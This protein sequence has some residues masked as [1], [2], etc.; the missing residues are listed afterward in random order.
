MMSVK[1]DAERGGF[2]PYDSAGNPLWFYGIFQSEALFYL[3]VCYD[4]FFGSP[5]IFKYRVKEARDA[6]LGAHFSQTF[7]G[8]SL[9]NTN[10]DTGAGFNLSPE[11][12]NATSY[13]FTPNLEYANYPLGTRGQRDAEDFL[14]SQGGCVRATLT[15]QKRGIDLIAMGVEY[16]VKSRG[17]GQR[18]RVLSIQ[19]HERNDNRRIS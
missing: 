12:L 2:F 3:H 16:E 10:D 11:Q 6:C 18:Y 15:Q 4:D 8:S 9:A 14:T 7:S 13:P 17:E 5:V 1:F 19:T